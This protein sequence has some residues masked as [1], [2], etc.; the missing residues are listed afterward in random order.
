[1]TDVE[2]LQLINSLSEEKIAEI[3]SIDNAS[4]EEKVKVIAISVNG[5]K[6]I[7]FT[8]STSGDFSYKYLGPRLRKL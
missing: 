7:E 8:L 4:D 2:L 6:R 1:M 3:E 5:I